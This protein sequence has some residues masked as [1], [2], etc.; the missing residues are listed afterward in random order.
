MVE[1]SRR[2]IVVKCEESH[3]RV[4]WKS[5]LS[6]H[7]FFL[8]CLNFISLFPPSIVET[9]RD[10]IGWKENMLNWGWNRIMFTLIEQKLLWLN[11]KFSSCVSSHCCLE[12]EIIRLM[13][14]WI[15]FLLLGVYAKI[16]ENFFKWY[17]F[18]GREKLSTR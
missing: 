3:T 2:H 10:W 12:L 9:M 14:E 4:I 11:W 18:M 15:E 7:S 8:H 5:L 13:E 6:N 16:G 17:F 1:I